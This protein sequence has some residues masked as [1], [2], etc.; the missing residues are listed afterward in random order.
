MNLSQNPETETV[1]IV[2][3]ILTKKY[4]NHIKYLIKDLD[5]KIA[6]DSD[7][8]CFKVFNDDN[9]IQG[10]SRVTTDIQNIHKLNKMLYIRL[11]DIGMLIT[12]LICKKINLEYKKIDRFMWN[13]YKS[14]EKGK[15][16][17]D[18][19]NENFYSIIYSLN[20]SD[21][22]LEVGDKKIYDI[23]DEAKIFKSNIFHK[24]IGPIKDKFR[25]NLNIVLE[26]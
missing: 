7:G 15:Q 8:D 22:Y 25:L 20:T 4:I 23:E 13:F 12:E 5:F 19:K 14:G 17:I 11:N 24:G 2:N 10:M 26:I 9:I 18:N 16:H 21:G 6:N 3:N 1:K